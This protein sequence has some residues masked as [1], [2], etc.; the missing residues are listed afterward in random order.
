MVKIPSRRHAKCSYSRQRH[1]YPDSNL[2]NKR[3]LWHELNGSV[4]WSCFHP[5][6]SFILFILRTTFLI[7]FG[8][9]RGN[10][11]REKWK[12]ERSFRS[13]G[14]KLSI[15][16]CHMLVHLR[17]EK[18]ERADI[19]HLFLSWKKHTDLFSP[20]KLRKHTTENSIPKSTDYTRWWKEARIPPT[21]HSPRA[22]SL[23]LSPSD[24]EEKHL[25][26]LQRLSIKRVAL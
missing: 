2:N 12:G 19:G 24:S 8:E 5:P 7:A 17:K 16:S 25:F 26:T 20:C 11:N 15:L 1:Q 10:K 18:R 21:F 22:V 13:S 9:G 14:R 4:C 23:M 3:P 6:E